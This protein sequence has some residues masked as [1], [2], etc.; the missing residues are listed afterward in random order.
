MPALQRTK[1]R[2]LGTGAKQVGRNLMGWGGRYWLAFIWPVSQ[3]VSALWITSR[4]RRDCALGLR[5]WSRRLFMPM[6]RSIFYRL[7]RRTL[8]NSNAPGFS[9]GRSI[10]RM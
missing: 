4:L 7:L 1:R 10:S 5:N 9:T 6:L 2:P 3:I 8:M